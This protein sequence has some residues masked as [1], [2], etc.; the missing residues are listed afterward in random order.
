MILKEKPWINR[1]LK[2]GLDEKMLDVLTSETY[3]FK[4][5]CSNSRI[6]L[7]LYA[8]LVNSFGWNS[9]KTLFREYE[10]LNDK[11]RAFK[12]D[13][14]KWDQFICRFSNIVGL[15]ISPLFYFWAIPFSEKAIANL[16]N[17]TPWL[18]DDEV[19]RMYAD[20]VKYVRM[21]YKNLLLG[22]EMLYSSCPLTTE[23]LE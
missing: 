2:H 3:C 15:D 9:Y 14:D 19:T 21:K 5:W 1:Y 16:N 8:Q 4:D 23:F 12:T 6:G 11:E 13:L 7:F 20:R 22:N 17:L 10:S 18:P